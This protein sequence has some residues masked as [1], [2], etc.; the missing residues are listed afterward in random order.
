METNTIAGLPCITGVSTEVVIPHTLE[1][2]TCAITATNEHSLCRILRKI[3]IPNE[4]I[5][6]AMFQRVTIIQGTPLTK[7]AS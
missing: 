1:N 2:I 7:A 3:G 4:D 6:P 5:R